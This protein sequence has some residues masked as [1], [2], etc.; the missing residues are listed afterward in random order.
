MRYLTAGT[1]HIRYRY[2]TVILRFQ[3]K[4]ARIVAAVNG[5]R[6]TQ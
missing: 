3:S 2:C 6:R 1:A 4:H 5:S